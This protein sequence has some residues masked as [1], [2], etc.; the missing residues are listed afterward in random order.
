MDLLIKNFLN[1]KYPG[2]TEYLADHTNSKNPVMLIYNE[3]I[4]VSPI[5]THYQLKKFQKHK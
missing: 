2:V 4:S 5:T 3:K 1:K